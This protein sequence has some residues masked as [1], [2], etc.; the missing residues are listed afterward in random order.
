MAI[1][2]KRDAIIRVE[3]SCGNIA[4]IQIKDWNQDD[5]I[6]E[7]KP[8]NAM[9]SVSVYPFEISG[10]ECSKCK[11]EI[12]ASFSVYEYPEGVYETEYVSHGV[13]ALDVKAAVSVCLE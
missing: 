1:K 9:G 3:C 7:S 10:L 6:V 11:K 4:R 12:D 13:N 2:I 5:V 8:D